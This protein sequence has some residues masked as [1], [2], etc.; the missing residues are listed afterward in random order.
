MH[1]DNRHNSP[2]LTNHKVPQHAFFSSFLS[3][4]GA[5]KTRF[6]ISMAN[7]FRCFR[8]MAKNVYCYVTAS[9]LSVRL[10]LR[11]S[12]MSVCPSIAT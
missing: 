4:T 10:L 1:Y 6:K 11:N 7:V 2:L 9:C 12:V 5:G 8:K 3:V